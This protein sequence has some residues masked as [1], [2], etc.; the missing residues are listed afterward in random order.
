MARG[1][2]SE[3]TEHFGKNWNNDPMDIPV[4]PRKKWMQKKYWLIAGAALLLPVAVIA[5]RSVSSVSY[6]AD[7]STLVFGEVQRGNFAVLVR[8]PGTLVPK[9]IRLV[10]SNVEGRVERIFSRAGTELKAGQPLIQLS[11]P[12]LLTTR[13]ETQFELEALSAEF[14]AAQVSM[15]SQLLDLKAQALKAKLDYESAKYKLD[16]QSKLVESG[17]VSRLDYESTKASVTTGEQRWRTE[18]QRVLKMGE[19]LQSTVQAHTARLGKTRNS[20]ERIKYQIESLTVTA[21]IDGTLQEMPLELGQQIALGANVGKIS[22]HDSLMARLR[23]QETQIRDVAVGQKTIIDTRS[24][25]VEGV[26]S[27]I[28]PA[29][30]SGTVLVDIDIT[31]ALPPEAKPDMSVDG[32]IETAM[33]S[34]ALFV[35]R[36]VFAQS[37]SKT[38]VYRVADKGGAAERIPVELGRASTSQVEVLAGLKPGDRIIVS[39]PTAWEKYDRIVI[40]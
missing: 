18:E 22:R 27:R 28:D 39:D 31:A 33:A 17:T 13:E 9:D 23:V 30:T 14:R 35:S 10:T 5:T 38:T 21:S 8:G 15:Q 36:P 40:N 24:S 19:N 6:I 37:F 16:L 20:L 11:N 29:I 26:V 7:A 2:L 12:A 32:V 3:D 34:D 25:K 4:A 1:L